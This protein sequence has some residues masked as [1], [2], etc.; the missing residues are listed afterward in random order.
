MIRKQEQITFNINFIFEVNIFH[1]QRKFYI[2]IRG[3]LSTQGARRG[4]HPPRMP[5]GCDPSRVP[6]DGHHPP[7]VPE[8]AIH[9]GARRGASSTQGARRVLY[10]QGARRWTSSAQGARRV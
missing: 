1:P 8:G 10:T 3:A 5:D 9:Q 4:H 6:E 7:R 2:H